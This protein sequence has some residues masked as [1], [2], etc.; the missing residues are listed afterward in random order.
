MAGPLA[1][2]ITLLLTA[3]APDISET[4][5]YSQHP[6]EVDPN[7]LLVELGTETEGNLTIR[8][9]AADALH[10]GHNTV[11]VELT[12]GDTPVTSAQV[13]LTPVW[14]TADRTL[15]PPVPSTANATANDDDRFEAGA[16]FVQ[17]IGED[18]TWEMWMET[19]W[20]NSTTCCLCWMRSAVNV[21]FE[22]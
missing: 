1:L 16:F 10:L 18:G 4:D 11:W 22:H 2:L 15:T 13:T 7:T 17:P 20:S 8:V 21:H 5:F 14:T 19:V 6:E 9:I 3:C 12:Q